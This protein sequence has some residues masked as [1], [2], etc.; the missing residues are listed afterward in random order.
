[1]IAASELQP[2]VMAP[3]TAGPPSASEPPPAPTPAVVIGGMHRSG[4][5]FVANLLGSAGLHLGEELLGA[6]FGNPLGHFEDLAFFDLHKRV[7]AANGLHPDG[8]TTREQ[9]DVP[10]ALL[11]EARDLAE[12]RRRVG[13]PWGWKEPRTVLFLDLWAELLP[14]ARFVFVFRR[15][16]DV[17]D[18]LF[19]RGDELILANPRLAI[20]TWVAYNRRIRD[21]IASHPDR[22]SVFELTQFTTRPTEVFT[23]L[24]ERLGVPLQDP[25]AVFDP[26]LL[27]SDRN[28]RRAALL[29]EIAPEAGDLYLHLRSLAAATA[30]LPDDQCGANRGPARP[31]EERPGATA[32]ADW[33][34]AAAAGRRVRDLQNA[35]DQSRREGEES[36]AR[37]H[38]EIAAL[39]DTRE[40]LQ[41][42][43]THTDLAA[44]HDA[45]ADRVALLEA[46][47][48]AAR[49]RAD[50]ACEAA[51]R[52]ADGMAEQ[53]Q[54]ATDL[55]EELAEKRHELTDVTAHAMRLE[56]AEAAHRDE[57][58]ALSLRLR[59]AEAELGRLAA[60][61][62]DVERLSLRLRTAEAELGRQAAW[63]AT[64]AEQRRRKPLPERLARETR[65]LGRQLMGLLPPQCGN[66]VD[67]SRCR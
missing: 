43:L 19:R 65:R 62:E 50:E 4:T 48:A 1:M 13:R 55:Q 8:F 26:A 5:S 28:P 58:E 29:H 21:F 25:A 53:R 15:P 7:L 60:Q 22:A 16:W 38:A 23:V 2:E 14:E 39:A 37:L 6:N 64:V 10:P 47:T 56:A 42:A 30:P 61:R 49:S 40:Q 12:A 11:V 27:G 45:L 66:L 63:L 31:A 41:H 18:S 36:S 54:I 44:D 46:E 24:R 32:L 9:I 59:T 33:A 52:L 51:L 35:L 3:P 17:V 67:G 20:D 34:T 57:V